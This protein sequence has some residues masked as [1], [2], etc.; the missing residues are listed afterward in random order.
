MKVTP[1]AARAAD[2]PNRDCRSFYLL[3]SASRQPGTV[4]RLLD[5]RGTVG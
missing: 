1:A 4:C 2:L 3:G 5:G